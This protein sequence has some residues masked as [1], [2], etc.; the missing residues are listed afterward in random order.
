MNRGNT[1]MPETESTGNS[2]SAANTGNAASAGIQAIPDL[3]EKRILFI[4]TGSINAALTPYW[5]HW[6]RQSFPRITSDLLVTRSAQR[7]VTLDA[8]RRL[9]GGDVWTDDY[10]DPS[11]P[12]SAHV[13]I[14]ERVDAF[15]VFPAT[16]DFAMR[17]A[18]GNCDTPATMALQITE[19]PIVLAT[20]F[21]AGNAVVEHNME[22]PAAAPERLGQP[23][24]G[25]VQRREAKM[26]GRDRLLPAV[27]PEGAGRNVRCKGPPV[28]PARGERPPRPWNPARRTDHERGGPTMKWNRDVAVVGSGPNGLAAAVTFARAGL[29]VDVYESQDEIGGGLRTHALFDSDVRHDICSAV[30][31]MAAVS[32]FFRRFDL[33]ARGVDLLRPEASYAHPLADGRAAVAYQDLDRTCDALGRDGAGWRRLM[34]PLIG[35]STEIGEALPLRLPFRPHVPADSGDARVAVP[36][37]RDGARHAPVRDRR[38]GRPPRRG[39]RARRR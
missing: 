15:A 34:A 14:G 29:H 26:G 36:G 24:R 28:A 13:E 5:L 6:L 12:E 37:P 3:G 2:G 9:V 11:L 17:L 18:S 30:H 4:V 20:A 31:P 23:D 25:G 1:E 10:T 27:G 38:G 19:K 8:L 39:G 22:P 35:R 21:P 33:S 16:L 32:P 7:F